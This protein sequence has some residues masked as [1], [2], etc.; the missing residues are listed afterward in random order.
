M[1][2]KNLGKNQ[3]NS[4]FC[5]F[6]EF[7]TECADSKNYVR[8]KQFCIPSYLI[9]DFLNYNQFK[10]SNSPVTATPTTAVANLF[11][12][13][14]YLVFFCQ[15]MKMVDYCEYVANLCV[16]TV[17]NLDKFSPCNIF[18]TVQTTVVNAGTDSYQTKLVPFLFYAKGRSVSDDLDKVIDHRYRYMK[19]DSN[20][21]SDEYDLFIPYPVSFFYYV[22]K[23]FE[24]NVPL[25]ILYIFASDDKSNFLSHGCAW[26]KWRLENDST[27]QIERFESMRNASAAHKIWWKFGKRMSN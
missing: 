25:L 19:S 2:P 11:E 16:L 23:H 17:Y 12:N 24:I 13:L 7:N 27:V 21:M 9:K 3:T 4:F 14:E 15:T 8:F 20:R 5:T 6:D 18:Y 10:V 26:A 1:P 22:V